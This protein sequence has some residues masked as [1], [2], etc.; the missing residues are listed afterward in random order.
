MHAVSLV[1]L[2]L[3]LAMWVGP[4]ASRGDIY[5]I[6][7]RSQQKTRQLLSASNISLPWACGSALALGGGSTGLDVL[8]FL[9]RLLTIVLSH[10]WPQNW[11]RVLVNACGSLMT[12]LA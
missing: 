5:R 1:M 6:R 4:D 10:I 7:A 3:P 2:R 9:H 12:L 11:L 8:H